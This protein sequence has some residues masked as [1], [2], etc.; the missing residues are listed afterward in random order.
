M[1]TTQKTVKQRLQ[2]AFICMTTEQMEHFEEKDHKGLQDWGRMHIAEAIV[3]PFKE[4]DRSRGAANIR[5]SRSVL[6]IELSN[7]T[8][9]A[10]KVALTT[11][12]MKFENCNGVVKPLNEAARDYLSKKGK[13]TISAKD[14]GNDFTLCAMAE[15]ITESRSRQLAEELLKGI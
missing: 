15:V 11:E 7:R 5:E 10:T 9:T 6:D 1:S 14:F 3:G 2:E 13:T 12:R 8:K 4:V